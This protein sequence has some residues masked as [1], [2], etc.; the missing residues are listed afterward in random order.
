MAVSRGAQ[1]RLKTRAPVE[2]LGAGIRAGPAGGPGARS[3]AARCRRRASEAGPGHPG[4][5]TRTGSTMHFSPGGGTEVP[6]DRR[7]A[8]SFVGLG[9]IDHIEVARAIYSRRPRFLVTP[10]TTVCL[11]IGQFLACQIVNVTRQRRDR[12]IPPVFRMGAIPLTIQAASGMSTSINWLAST[13]HYRAPSTGSELIT[14]PEL[15]KRSLYV[16]N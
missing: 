13:L 6:R 14:R 2:E 16:A 11:A 5:A 7:C 1:S 9:S 10:A 12:L 4:S 3:R 8:R 15:S